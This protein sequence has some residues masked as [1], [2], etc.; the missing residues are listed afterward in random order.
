MVPSSKKLLMSHFVRTIRFAVLCA[1]IANTQTLQAQESRGSGQW[2]D[3]ASNGK[4]EIVILPW[5]EGIIPARA[6]NVAL[7]GWKSFQLSQRRQEPAV[8]VQWLGR[9]LISLRNV[10]QVDVMVP[11]TSVNVDY[12]FEILDEA[13]IR[14]QLTERGKKLPTSET[15]HS[16]MVHSIQLKVLVPGEEFVEQ[17]DVSAYFQLEPGREYTLRVRRW[18]GGRFTSSE[19]L[20]AQ[21]KDENAG[22][23]SELRRSIKL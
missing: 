8:D 14:A 20:V 10:S 9:V 23:K 2:T 12:A 22:F 13:G 15:E 6:L 11:K 21:R 7:P 1:A 3:H 16:H 18:V 4:L 17:F 19:D 5:Q